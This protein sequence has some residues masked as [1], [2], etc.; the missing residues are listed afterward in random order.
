MSPGPRTLSGGVDVTTTLVMVSQLRTLF[1]R[2]P[3]L[4]TPKESAELAEFECYRQI[5]GSLDEIRKEA[6]LAGF[7][8][9]WR[10]GDLAAILELGAR[11]P[12]AVF[13]QDLDMQMYHAMAQL[14]TA[15]HPIPPM[16][17]SP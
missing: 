7:R 5:R 4:P 2:L 12:Q 11:L 17:E 16:V 9:A 10:S 1:D 3:H 6:V 8:E 14:R 13:E 15:A